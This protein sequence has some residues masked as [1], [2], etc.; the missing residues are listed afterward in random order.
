MWASIL[1]TDTRRPKKQDGNFNFEYD[2]SEILWAVYWDSIA[3]WE[4]IYDEPTVDLLNRFA[5]HK[6]GVYSYS[7][8]YDELPCL[9]LD[10]LQLL[11]AEQQTA[12]EA[13]RRIYGR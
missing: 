13:Y 10:A 2:N 11:N 7:M 9:W 4:F 8:I 1:N 5:M 3:D 6:Q 12:Q